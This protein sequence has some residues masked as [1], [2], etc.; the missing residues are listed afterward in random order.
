MIGAPQA[1]ETELV[2]MTE[3]F[4]PFNYQK[5][6]VIDGIATKIVRKLLEEAQ[7]KYKIEIVPWRR[8]YDTALHRPNTLI[9][10][11]A[12]TEERMNKFHWI[13]KI[14]NR[15]LFMFRLRSRQDL[16]NMTIAEAKERAK[17]AV[18]QGDASTESVIALGFSKNNLTMIRDTTSGNLTVRHVMG[19]RSDFFL[20]NPY[21]MKYRVDI[22]DLP[23][24]FKD[25]YV[26]HDGD[27]YYIAAN[28]KTDPSILKALLR[29]NEILQENGYI[30]KII[31][32][33][34][35]F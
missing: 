30:D 33:Y 13:C 24:L 34:L 6:E 12:K 15:K 17:I 7:L 35:T 32:A 27:G 25:Q 21:T 29:A 4:P 3:Q 10:T 16:A 18:I 22:G 28:L 8:A 20:L 23:D 19:G 14:S 31:S 1:S 2:I 11:M 26:I 5:G 9:Y